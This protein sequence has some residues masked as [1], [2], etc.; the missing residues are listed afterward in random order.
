MSDSEDVT[1][2][3]NGLARKQVVGYGYESDSEANLSDDSESSSK[4]VELK[5]APKDAIS[6][7]DEDDMF[8][9]DDE[10]QKKIEN[11]D[12]E[13]TDAFDLDKFELEN[14]P[15]L[16]DG[17]NENSGA[18]DEI[19]LE[20]FSLRKE[21]EDGEFND[22]STYAKATRDDD[23][24]FWME[25]L[26]KSDIAKAKI[27][28]ELQDRKKADTK[29]LRSKDVLI[30][31]LIDL[32][33]PSETPYEALSRLRPAK[34]KRSKRTN[35]SIENE[36]K[37]KSQ[38][39]ELTDICETLLNSYNTSQIYEVSR[40]QLMRAFKQLSGREHETRGTKR[41]ADEAEI[42]QEHQAD[43]SE[44]EDDDNDPKIWEFRWIGEQDINGPYTTYEMRY[45]VDNYFENKAE[46]RKCG[47]DAFLHIS[48]LDF[49]DES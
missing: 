16:G 36:K 38:V 21:V 15:T 11:L 24:E 8:A 44:A 27:A 30:G 22:G 40:E 43:H 41:S 3:E 29:Q 31:A 32:L 23:E 28:Q 39:F 17:D 4:A 9:S 26:E 46:A 48:E 25:G 42:S 14:Q 13:E 19:E 45:W 5:E 2:T 47:E 35:D 49:A 33:E 6:E 12:D 20:A 1:D 7:E 18:K 34:S 10:T 37:R